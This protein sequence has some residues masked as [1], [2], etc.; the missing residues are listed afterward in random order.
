MKK[1]NKI[2]EVEVTMQTIL[3]KYPNAT[4]I[5][6]KYNNHVILFPLGTEYACIDNDAILINEIS[7]TKLTN[8]V[9]HFSYQ[10]LEEYLTK[11][12]KMGHKVAIIDLT[13][14]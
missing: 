7:K 9:T 10:Y 6:T 8:N 13:K 1:S 11:L 2:I 4:E 14:Y 3:E 5:K 12:I